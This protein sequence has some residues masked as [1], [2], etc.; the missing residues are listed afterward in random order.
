[1]ILPILIP[2]FFKFKKIIIKK[3]SQFV[4]Y[5]MA[6]VFLFIGIVNIN[7][8]QTIP[9]SRIELLSSFINKN[10]LVQQENNIYKIYDENGK[11]TG[12]IFFTDEIAFEAI[13][14]F[15]GPVPV[16]VHIKDNRIQKVE[17]LKNN[18]TPEYIN[19]LIKNN[20]LKQYENKSIFEDFKLDKNIHSYSGATISANAINNG[21]NQS[22]KKIYNLI[23]ESEE[24][25]KRKIFKYLFLIVG[26]ILTLFSLYKKNIKLRRFTILYSVIVLGFVNKIFLSINSLLTIVSGGIEANY[27]SPFL[28]LFL[29][30][31]IFLFFSGKIFCAYLCPFGNLIDIIRFLFKKIGINFFISEFKN[32]YFIKYIILF[33]YLFYFLPNSLTYKLEPFIYIFS[34]S[35]VNIYFVLSILIL[36]YSVIE[37]RFYCRYL[38]ALNAFFLLLLKLKNSVETINKKIK[39]N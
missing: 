12:I 6:V 34:V 36:I 30:T 1:M 20:F 21:I 26:L 2:T 31:L 24:T 29:F 22:L 5:T 32:F 10:N 39:K 25:N 4:L 8:K 7:K 17:L 11:I 15:N 35:V 3:F 18:E 27:I 28:I 23:R 37:Y 14:G 38:C 16:M 19:I 9:L 13:N 33:I